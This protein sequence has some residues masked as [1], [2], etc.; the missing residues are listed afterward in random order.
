[1]R[2][3]TA[4]QGRSG[5]KGT[6]ARLLVPVVILSWSLVARAAGESGGI[7]TYEE[8]YVV[9]TFTAGGTLVPPA[10]VTRVEVLVVAGG[11]GGGGSNNARRAGG[12]GGGGEVI[13]EPSFEIS[14]PVTVT[15][16]AGGQGGAG[17]AV[18]GSGGDAAFGPL[19]ARG[20]GGGGSGNTGGLEGGSGGGG[21]ATNSANPIPGGSGSAGNDGG[22]G[23]S[24]KGGGG[25]GAAGAGGAALAAAA[26]EGGAGLHLPQFA[27]VN[28]GW[29]AG[30]GGGGAG[31]AYAPGAGNHG[32]GNGGPSGAPGVPALPNTGG[33]GGGAGGNGAGGSGASGIVIVRYLARQT[34]LRVYNDV[35][36]AIGP[37][38]VAAGQGPEPVSDASSS[39]DWSSAAGPD[40]PNK[41]QVRIA[42]GALPPGLRLGVDT[43]RAPAPVVVEETARDFVTGI[44]SE[45]ATGQ[46][47][48][49]TLEV[50]DFGALSGGS[51]SL[52]IEYTLTAQDP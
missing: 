37:A 11:G 20:G 50:T 2:A 7:V 6:F 17:N 44:G 19:V 52:F 24:S 32:G 31:L 33:G 10:G 13:Y 4:A 45:S 14:G 23:R 30:G 49:Y 34:A 38:I 18:G 27:H 15:V 21:G 36:L 26:G 28:G 42:G 43:D 40:S 41:I 46:A 25:G 1:M 47:L 29:F 51:T 8:D 12:G 3:E 9:H 22:S 39:M 35:S 5:R 16:G 48:R